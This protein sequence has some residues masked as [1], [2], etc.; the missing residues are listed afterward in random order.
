MKEHECTHHKQHSKSC[1]KCRLKASEAKVA[2]L[3]EALDWL[4]TCANT[5]NSMTYGT[6][7]TGF[8]KGVAEEALKESGFYEKE[9]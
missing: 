6:L 5:S 2:T 1:L 4:I 9:I 7:S 3:S 8:V